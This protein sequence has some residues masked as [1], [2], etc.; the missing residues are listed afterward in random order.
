MRKIIE[1]CLSFSSVF[2]WQ[3]GSGA[4]ARHGWNARHPG[5]LRYSPNS[6]EIQPVIR[7]SFRFTAIRANRVCDPRSTARFSFN[8]LRSLSFDRLPLAAFTAFRRQRNASF[9]VSKQAN[10]QRFLRNFGPFYYLAR[11]FFSL[12][13]ICLTF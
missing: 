3:E 12:C 8:L 4:M 11:K 7:A 1:E 13:S 6:R 2:P 9:R 10:A 5:H